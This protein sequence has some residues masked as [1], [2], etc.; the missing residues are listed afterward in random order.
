MFL[1]L[2]FAMPIYRTVKD[3]YW[4]QAM[5]NL[6]KQEIVQDRYEWL[7]QHPM[8]VGPSNIQKRLQTSISL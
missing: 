6:N 4:T 1:A 7:Q 3:A 5:K 2:I 8:H